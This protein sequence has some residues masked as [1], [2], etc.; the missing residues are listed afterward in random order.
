VRGKN[1]KNGKKS[2]VQIRRGGKWTMLRSQGKDR[3]RPEDISTTS[4]NWAIRFDVENGEMRYVSKNNRG[5][6][7]GE[8]HLEV[9]K[10][11]RC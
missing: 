9:K 7:V 6:R 4:S 10:D 3:W 5:K 1:G 8:L 11:E 2:F